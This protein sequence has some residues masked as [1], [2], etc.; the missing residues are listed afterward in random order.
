M[1]YDHFDE[2]PPVI[3]D[4]NQE[5]FYPLTSLKSDTDQLN[6]DGSFKLPNMNLL[7]KNYLQGRAIYQYF[8][9]ICGKTALISR[10]SLIHCKRR[11]TDKSFAI[12]ETQRQGILK[13]NM[14][15]ISV[16]KIKKKNTRKEYRRMIGCKDCSAIIA[17]EVVNKSMLFVLNDALVLDA[18]E[19]QARKNLALVLNNQS[20]DIV[21]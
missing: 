11:D 9:A 14:E 13:A 8:C 10:M 3:D 6:P 5:T 7:Q 4:D 21:S 17:Y 19:A 15:V 16:L 2:L 1:F 18:K 20:K 12:D